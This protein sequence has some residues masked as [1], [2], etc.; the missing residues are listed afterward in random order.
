MIRSAVTL[1][2]AIAL[3]LGLGA[4]S[5]AGGASWLVLWDPASF[6]LAAGL[7]VCFA[8]PGLASFPLST[9]RRAV[10]TRAA[11]LAA[12][13]SLLLALVLML[14]NIAGDFS[15]AKFGSGLA[16]AL[17][18]PLYCLIVAGLCSGPFR[19]SKKKD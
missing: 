18:T 5:R 11:L 6:A 19:S 4:L 2:S 3:C 17:L 8:L 10:L 1:I 9:R 13:V 12:P 14:N 7:I 16:V 15:M